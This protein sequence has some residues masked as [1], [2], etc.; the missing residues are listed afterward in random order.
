M[1]EKKDMEDGTIDIVAYVARHLDQ[2]PDEAALLKDID[3]ICRKDNIKI[4]GYKVYELV[5]C[6]I[7]I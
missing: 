2:Y 6:L 3:D 7:D 1:V 5:S 4:S